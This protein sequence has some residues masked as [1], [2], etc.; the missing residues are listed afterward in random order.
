MLCWRRMP[1]V[2][3]PGSA[4]AKRLD[5]NSLAEKQRERVDYLTLF[6]AV[7]SVSF[8]ISLISIVFFDFFF[9]SYLFRYFFFDFLSRGPVVFLF[10]YPA[11]LFFSE[12]F[13]RLPF[14]VL[15]CCVYALSFSRKI[16]LLFCFLSGKFLLFCRLYFLSGQFLLFYRC[17]SSL[18]LSLSFALSL[19]SLFLLFALFSFSRFFFAIRQQVTVCDGRPFGVFYIYAKR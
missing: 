7:F 12:F 14:A 13:V 15:Y 11:G 3:R 18:P 10:F 19:F 17:S 9:L 6:F 1:W 4:V 8:F 16:T 2:M 5:R